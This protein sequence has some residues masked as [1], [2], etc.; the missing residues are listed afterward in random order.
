MP[1][2]DSEERMSSR[3]YEN[4]GRMIMVY[5]DT[6]DLA[7]KSGEEMFIFVLHVVQWSSLAWIDWVFVHDSI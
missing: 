7:L 6:L 4:N 5:R 1:Q 2:N 3:E